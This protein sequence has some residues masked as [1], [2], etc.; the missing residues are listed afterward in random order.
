MATGSF[1]VSLLIGGELCGR[2]PND[3]NLQEKRLY[4]PLSLCLS[5]HFLG[6]CWK[7][8]DPLPKKTSPPQHTQVTLLSRP[9]ECVSLP[10]PSS[11]RGFVFL[12]W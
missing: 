6:I 5:I 1:V 8:D 2:G 7:D 11:T 9:G 10:E 4:F 3:E 12:S